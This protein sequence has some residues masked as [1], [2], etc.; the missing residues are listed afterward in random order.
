M[1]LATEVVLNHKHCTNL[2]FSFFIALSS[3]ATPFCLAHATSPTYQ[4]IELPE[5]NSHVKWDISPSS[6]TITYAL[7]TRPTPFLNGYNCPML[8]SM[9]SITKPL[10]I[11]ANRLRQIIKD[12]FALWSEQI[13]I[14]FREVFSEDEAQILIGA[15]GSN[16]SVSKASTGIQ[17]NS[18]SANEGFVFLKKAAICFDSKIPWQDEDFISNDVLDI[19]ATLRHEIGHTL[20]LD[21]SKDKLSV[22]FKFYRYNPLNSALSAVDIEGAQSL[23]GVRPSVITEKRKH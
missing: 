13:P 11:S 8:D 23:Y 20:G 18:I 15:N 10:N 1:D 17:V 22:M 21:H 12:S 9:D 4:L 19:G 7:V 2:Y 3:I 5:T 6:T 14:E 16:T